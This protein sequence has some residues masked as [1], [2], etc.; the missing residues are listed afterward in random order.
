MVAVNGVPTGLKVLASTEEEAEEELD[1]IAEAQ[2]SGPR[3]ALTV[4]APEDWPMSC[5]FGT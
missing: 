5:L 1:R 3:G 2:V 4:L